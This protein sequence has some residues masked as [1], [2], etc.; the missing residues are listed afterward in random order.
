M[1]ANV[2]AMVREGISAL[3]AGDKEAARA[4]LEKAIEIDDHNEQAWL[5]MSAV[6]DS[7]ED[8]RTCLEN[9]LAINPASERAQQGLQYLDQSTQIEGMSAPPKASP[10]TVPPPPPA[11]VEPEA[12]ATGFDSIPSSVEWAAPEPEP[13]SEPPARRGMEL[14]QDDYDSWVDTLNL[15]S[16][17]AGST[18]SPFYSEVDDLP[19][20]SAPEEAPIEKKSRRQ[21]HED[22]QEAP[23]S[24]EPAVEFDDESFEEVEYESLFPDIP[25]E[26]RA[27][28]LPGTKERLPMPLIIIL[29]LLLGLNV[30]AA[31]LLAQNLL[32]T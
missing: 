4:L 1:A 24:S 5:W 28:R 20:L 9:A 7:V 13:S 30:A 16:T 32:T 18:V 12:P 29:G 17:D 6:L 31:I 2:D 21:E 25:D 26:I 11:R 23:R 27:T 14:S 22:L 8:Q 15:S 10:A 3:K 19:D